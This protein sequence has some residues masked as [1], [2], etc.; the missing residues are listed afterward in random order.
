MTVITHAISLALLHFVWQGPLVALLLW[1]ALATLRKA[2][3]QLRYGAS[4]AALAGMVVLPVLTGWVLYRAPVPTSAIVQGF[5][6]PDSIGPG[7]SPAPTLP[8]VAALE[9]WALPVWC[10]GVLLL[11]VRLIWISRYVARLRREG[12]PAAV[13][14][15]EAVSRLACRMKIDRPVRV[16]ISSL[17]DSPSVAGWLRPVILLPAATL[18]NLSVEQLEAVLTHELAHVRRHDYVVNILQILAE[19]LLF[20]QPAVW[21]VSSRIRNERELCCDDVVVGIGGDPIGYARALTKLE[22]IRV[23]APELTMGG[24]AGPLL[25]RIRRLT[26]EVQE[27]PASKLPAVLALCLAL[28]CLLTNLHWAQAQP[29]SATDASVPKD[30]IW[31]DT[32]K[33]GDLP[34]MVRALGT[35]TVPT[36]AELK[37]P[38][39][40]SNMVQTGQAASIELSGSIGI[41]IAGKVTRVDS[42]PVNGTVTGVVNLQSPVPELVGQAID[43]T[44]RVKTLEDVMYVG[45]PAI[46]PSDGMATMFK[47]EPDGA[48]AK[49]V[50]V[51]FGAPSVTGIQVLRAYNPAIA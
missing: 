5:A 38:T 25:Y 22:R 10:V 11:A 19:T 32:V 14:L 45:R 8:W 21:W 27:Q 34:I 44:I 17:T 23:F 15:T 47:V 37:I 9:A 4:C 12:H 13:S 31:V 6:V 36:E 28:T 43:G 35:I 40:V 46:A 30:S 2:S 26:G 18:L 7:A 49:R 20:Y 33:Y 29:R 42:S 16:L 3:A 24:T 50:N 41:T 48:H 1:V 51:R 39:K